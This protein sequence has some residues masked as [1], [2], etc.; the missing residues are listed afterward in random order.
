MHKQIVALAPSISET[1][2]ALGAAELLVGVTDYCNHPKHCQIL[3][4]IGGFTTPDIDKILALDPDLILATTLHM[5][6]KLAVFKEHKIKV[7]RIEAKQL[8]DSPE[9]IIQIGKAI[10]M[11]EKAQKLAQKIQLRIDA[12]LEKAKTINKK[13]KVCYLCTSTPFCSYKPKC[14]TNKLITLLGG[15][16]IDYPEKNLADA[17]ANANPEV[18]IIPYKPESNDYKI[19]AK[20]VKQNKAIHQTKAFTSNAVLNINGELLSRPGPRAAL[21]LNILYNL[22]HSKK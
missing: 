11:E 4:K 7:I 20:F 10:N 18:I 19:Q 21:G 17:I 3:P 13:V 15:K 9:T 8:L 6:D 16:L 1:I 22:I 5:E 14:Q 2:C 12:I